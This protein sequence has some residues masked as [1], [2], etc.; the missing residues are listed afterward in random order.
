MTCHVG[1]SFGPTLPSRFRVTSAVEEMVDGVTEGEYAQRQEKGGF[2]INVTTVLPQSAHLGPC[3]VFSVSG[4]QPMVIERDLYRTVLDGLF[5]GV[6][7]MDRNRI[8][9][10]WN[11]GAERIT[12]FN[13][14]EVI[15]KACRDNLLKHVDEEGRNL[16]FTE[17]CPA[18]NTI[19]DGEV[20]EAQV[21]LHHKE[22]YRVPVLVR[23]SPIRDES[24]KITGAVEI[25]SDNRRMEEMAARIDELE[26]LALL[27]PLT[28]IGNRRFAEIHL[29]SSLSSMDRYGLPFCVFF[30][31]IDHFK[32]VNDT[33]GHEAGDRVL[34][35][36]ASTLLHSLR[37]SDVASRWGGEEFLT[38]VPHVGRHEIGIIGKKILSLVEQSFLDTPEGPLSVT[39]SVGAA[40]ARQ[41]DSVASLVDR[42]DHLMY[43]SKRKGRN[44][45]TAED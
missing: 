13:K 39:V 41:N 36:V 8:I 25:F 10:Y 18:F 26:K 40:L 29:E 23:I 31:D 16:C 3:G 27:D 34:R 4:S 22:G 33:Y 44:T 37:A 1:E 12:G 43:Q 38:V 42:A 11:T 9:L 15:G 17:Y 6:Y 5:D 2:F 19:M 20:R 14:H 35:M 24:G 21:Y 45:V 28:R 7:F 30:L 32:R